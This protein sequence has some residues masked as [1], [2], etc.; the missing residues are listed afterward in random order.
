MFRR[1]VLMEATAPAKS[2]QINRWLPYW[3]VFQ[4]DMRQTMRNWV[5]LT[6]V[7]LSVLAAVGCLIFYTGKHQGAGIIQHASVLASDL[8]RYAALGSFTLVIA[9]TAGCISS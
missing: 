6:W 2:A 4:Y 5:Y 3:A 1:E 9:L 7:L 8:L